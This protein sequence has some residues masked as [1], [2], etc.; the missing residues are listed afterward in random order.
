MVL[1]E[2][3]AWMRSFLTYLVS[4]APYPIRMIFW[5]FIFLS[6]AGLMN[7]FFAFSHVCDSEGVLYSPDSAW[8][9]VKIQKERLGLEEKFNLTAGEINGSEFTDLDNQ[10]FFDNLK[11]ATYWLFTMGMDSCMVGGQ[12]IVNCDTDDPIKLEKLEYLESR[13]IVIYDEL[14]HEEATIVSEQEGLVTAQCDSFHPQLAFAGINIMNKELWLV[15]TI[16]LVLAP[17][18]KMVLDRR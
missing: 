13:Q 3:I 18:I 17:F 8:T 15:L 7:L 11:S 6:V 2:I 10:S 14:V 1:S 16:L 12:I 9:A 5:V 4:S